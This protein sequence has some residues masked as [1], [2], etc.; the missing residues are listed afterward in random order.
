M[1]WRTHLWCLPQVT[2]AVV[3]TLWSKEE[4]SAQSARKYWDGSALNRLAWCCF[5]TEAAHVHCQVGKSLHPSSCQCILSS[6]DYVWTDR[7][8]FRTLMGQVGNVGSS[9][10]PALGWNDF[11]WAFWSL[12]LTFSNTVFSRAKEPYAGLSLFS[13]TPLWNSS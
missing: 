8:P 1:V 2:G 3:C 9:L 12:G 4:L 13:M 7:G 11:Y 10:C 5:V 6:V